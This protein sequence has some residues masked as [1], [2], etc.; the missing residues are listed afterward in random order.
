MS[1]PTNGDKIAFAVCVILVGWSVNNIEATPL[2]LCC[3]VKTRWASDVTFV[4][5]AWK[6]NKF[7]H[8]L[9]LFVDDFTPDSS[10]RVR[11]Q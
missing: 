7:V 1:T 10:R 11:N 4:F 6:S 9:F 5:I 2:A 3:P 8:F